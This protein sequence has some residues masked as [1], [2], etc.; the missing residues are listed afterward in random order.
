MRRT[1][2]RRWSQALVVTIGIA[3]FC[4]PDGTQAFTGQARA[5]QASVGGV[6]TV[7]AD[8][9][10]LG[11]PGGAIFPHLDAREVSLPQGTIP[12]LLTGEVLHATTIG[13]ADRVESE[14]SLGNLVLSLAGNR[15]S[16]DFVMARAKAVT[17]RAGRGTSEIAGLLINGLQ[18]HPTGAPNQRVDLAGGR[19]VINEQVISPTGTIVNALHITVDGVAD[20]VIASANAS[21]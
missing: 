14:A 8:T 11:G 20:V 1:S 3:I 7:L 6:P 15:I 10:P 17:G 19:V 9:G 5:V 21:P 12:S 18:I 2:P 13:R 4:V 16:A